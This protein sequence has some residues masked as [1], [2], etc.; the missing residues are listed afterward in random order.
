MDGAPG[1]GA[2]LR[3]AKVPLLPFPRIAL[4][5]SW[6]IFVTSLREESAYLAGSAEALAS[7]RLR[8]SGCLSGSA[9][10]G[11]TFG[12]K[13]GSYDTPAPDGRLSGGDWPYNSL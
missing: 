7:P 12:N 10:D 8:R 1:F 11:A 2:P 13:D 3:G 9:M 6:A 5:P 4:A